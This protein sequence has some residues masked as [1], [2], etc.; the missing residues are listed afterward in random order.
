MKQSLTKSIQSEVSAR[1]V[2]LRQVIS[3]PAVIED[4]RSAFFGLRAALVSAPMRPR[5]PNSKSRN[6]I[7]PEPSP[8]RAVQ[9]AME[10]RRNGQ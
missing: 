2:A 3:V 7:H 9:H 10:H 5:K 4:M 8:D 6:M 1:G